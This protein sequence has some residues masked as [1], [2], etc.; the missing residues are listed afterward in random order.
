MEPWLVSA[1]KAPPHNLSA[2]N[3]VADLRFYGWSS[4]RNDLSAARVVQQAPVLSQ[5]KEHSASSNPD[6]LMLRASFRD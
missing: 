4:A 6:I 1:D 3:E 2:A 5:T